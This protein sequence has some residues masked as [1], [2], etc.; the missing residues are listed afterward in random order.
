MPFLTARVA[1]NLPTTAAN[2]L[3]RCGLAIVAFRQRRRRLRFNRLLCDPIT[4]SFIPEG[5]G[6]LRKPQSALHIRIEC[7][8]KIWTLE[9]PSVNSSTMKKRR[10][11]SFDMRERLG[12]RIP[13]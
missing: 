8:K 6:R 4:L 3:T 7:S 10:R 1:G 13:L 5:L 11:T 2:F 9:D 12:D